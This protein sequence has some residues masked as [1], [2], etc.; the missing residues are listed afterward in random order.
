MPSH[1]SATGYENLLRSG[2]QFEGKPGTGMPSHWGMM[3]AADYSDS[4][5]L[6]N[7]SSTAYPSA[8]ADAGGWTLP[9]DSPYAKFKQWSVAPDIPTLHFVG[10]RI[11]M[12][13]HFEFGQ[14]SQPYASELSFNRATGHLRVKNTWAID[15]KDVGGFWFMCSGIVT[16]WNTHLGSEEYP[17]DCR[18]FMQSIQSQSCTAQT[19]NFTACGW[20][21][22]S[23]FE[24]N[25]GMAMARYW[26]SF[27]YQDG[28]IDVNKNDPSVILFEQ[29]L[30][31]GNQERLDRFKANYKCYNYGSIPE[32]RVLPS[33]N[34]RV[35]KWRTMGRVAFEQASQVMPDGLTMYMTD[36]GTNCGFFMFK[37]DNRNNL[38]SGTLFAAKLTQLPG[39]TEEW[40][41]SWIRLGSATQAE[42]ETLIVN[43]NPMFSD[44]F[45]TATPFANKTCPPG[46][47]PT[48]TANS[49]F[50]LV[51]SSPAAFMEC[52]KVKPGMEK[53]A[54]FLETR[55]FA[56]MMGATTE[57]EKE[58]GVTFSVD[59]MEM[60][61]AYTRIGN[62]MTTD[63]KYGAVSRDINMVP[64]RCG[65]VFKYKLGRDWTATA[66]KVLIAGQP[67]PSPDADGNRCHLN[68]I[69][70]PDNL[71]HMN[72]VLFMAEDTSDHQ[73]N[74][75]W[76]YDLGSGSLSRILSS[77]WYAEVT[78]INF[79]VQDRYAYFM[80]AMQHPEQTREVDGTDREQAMK[81]RG[82]VGYIGPLDGAKL[83]RGLKPVFADI[84]V[85]TGDDKKKVIATNR[86][87]YER[88][89]VNPAW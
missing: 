81:E 3:K 83:R 50:Y 71:F 18:L 60:Y 21:G 4:W 63:A 24:G 85:P 34:T 33:G 82:Y 67:L 14:P 20:T 1:C 55:R 89:T 5:R 32:I 59:R 19:A 88:Y 2:D 58:E 84:P 86:V 44:I 61:V 15:G 54:A 78:G 23:S 16:P 51:G 43:V 40:T 37:M 46:F 26:G 73:N 6:L 7:K 70:N 74:V 72:D 25:G 69:S 56:S 62:G 76:A 30:G 87:C 38:S 77:P 65:A 66:A 57:F 41:V 47:S 11:F 12:V 13:N 27:P 80:L 9:A 39:T 68:K 42:L 75:L 17:A 49:N 64:N 28:F 29:N 36:D 10:P 48:N 31:F 79:A 35:T 52:L 8:A 45:E 53:A 22:Y